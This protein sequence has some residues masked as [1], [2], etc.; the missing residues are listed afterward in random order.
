METIQERLQYLLDSKGLTPY[1]LSVKTGISN[2]TLSRTLKKGSKPN[3]KTLELLCKYFEITEEWLLTGNANSVSALENKN[4]NKFFELASGKFLMTVKLVPIKAYAQYISECCD[5]EFVSDYQY[6]EVSFHVDKYARGNYMAFEI[7]GD[8]MDNGMLYDTPDKATAL[9]RE[10]GRQHWKDG[11]RD[12]LYGWVIVH[13][14]TILFKDII[15]QN[16]ETGIITCHSR[17]ESP[18]YADFEISLN[19]VK[20]IFKVIKRTF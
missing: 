11:F 17:N 10:L 12:S 3:S 7:K 14:D 13:I 19:D 1:Q 15:A 4:G 9:C 5:G 16:L 20:Q 8:S 6:E 2:S 18:E